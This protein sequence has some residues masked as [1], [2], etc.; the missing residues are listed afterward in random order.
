MFQH[1][2]NSIIRR[3]IVKTEGTFPK[4]ILHYNDHNV[5]GDEW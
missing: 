2:L 4:L 3:H 1:P 5:F